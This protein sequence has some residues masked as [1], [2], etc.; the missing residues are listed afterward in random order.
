M[1]DR[2]RI[3][4]RAYPLVNLGDNIA[5][6]FG[7]M[8][9]DTRLAVS[10]PIIV[11]HKTRTANQRFW[12]LAGDIGICRLNRR[13]DSPCYN[14]GFL[15][16]QQGV[17]K[18]VFYFADTGAGMDIVPVSDT[19]SRF[20]CQH[21]QRRTECLCG[22]ECS[23][24]RLASGHTLLNQIGG[25]QAFNVT[26]RNMQRGYRRFHVADTATRCYHAPR[27]LS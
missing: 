8:P 25:D 18:L 7:R 20:R 1:S 5:F 11:N 27:C 13:L 19:L 14:L 23:I 12:A 21:Q 4:R 24:Y 10:R 22:L 9:P 6:F 16:F 17:S 3:Q 15:S 26:V 2:I